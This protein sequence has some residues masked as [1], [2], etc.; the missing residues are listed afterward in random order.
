[1]D[2][3]A[4]RYPTDT[5]MRWKQMNPLWG[6]GSSQLINNIKIKREY[7]KEM[8]RTS[9][10]EGVQYLE[11]RVSLYGGLYELDP[12]PVYN[13]TNG[14][15]FFDSTG[16]AE[17]NVT[18]DVIQNFTS[19]HPDF[20]G[21]KRIIYSSRGR[22]SIADVKRAIENVLKF[23]RRYPSWIV[24]YDL[25]AEE[26]AGR[27]H[28]FFLDSFLTLYDDA[29]K[30]KK[31]DLY[32]HTAETNFA[33][34][35]KIS[36]HQDDPV[37]AMQ[38]TYDAIVLGA[39]RV[40]HGL[41]FIKHPYLMKILKERSIAVESCPVSNQLLGFQPDL[42]NHPAQTYLRY[43]IPVVLGSDDPGTF[44]YDHFTV[45]WYMA[46]FG[47]GLDL[48]DLKLMAENS[49]QYSAMSSEE[50]RSAKKK[51]ESLWKR[52]IE[53]TKKQACQT[54]FEGTPVFAKVLPIEGARSVSTKVYIYGANFQAGICKNVT[55]I[56]G[57]RN[58]T[59][60][61]LV[62]SELIIC[63]SPP[64]GGSRRRRHALSFGMYDTEELDNGVRVPVSIVFDRTPVYT[65]HNFT[66]KYE[67]YVHPPTPVPTVPK[68]QSGAT[69]TRC[70]VSSFILL[71][72]A[73][74]AV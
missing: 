49:L 6:R 58:A 42:R 11:N 18:I 62:T 20:I 59:K 25:V 27:S 30:R 24:G 71:C 29:T 40:G 31:I 2:N 23:H 8:L 67:P 61:K 74:L 22:S 4:Q 16:E 69:M 19:E 36:Q 52:Y 3:N 63:E 7:V 55:C 37:A 41:G 28:L 14:K 15:R 26:D 65:G 35:H 53:D 34:D 33:T 38:N 56:F 66:Y 68:P 51:F 13:R 44:G 64:I 17:L 10:E 39:R 57:K 47:W 43:G 73:Y 54:T 45:D 1:M 46:Y 12:N 5:D 9:L 60:T 48:A 70:S 72:A 32:L 50:K 21:M